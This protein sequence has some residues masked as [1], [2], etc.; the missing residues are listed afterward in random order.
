MARHRT[1]DPPLLVYGVNAV[2][3]A[4]AHGV[5]IERLLVAPGRATQAVVAEAHRRGVRVAEVDRA[6]LDR[7]AG[8]PHHQGAVA[9][10]PPY[11]YAELETIAEGRRG[12]LLLDSI[13]DPRNL[14]A[15]L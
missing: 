9:T 6:A 8:T 12:V 4:L 14:G 11:R 1:T 2:A 7:A 13:Q 10:T 15:I 5:P 3:G